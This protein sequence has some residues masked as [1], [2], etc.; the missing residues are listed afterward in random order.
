MIH[1]TLLVSF[2]PIMFSLRSFT[3]FNKNSLHFDS[4]VIVFKL[5][6]TVNKTDDCVCYQPRIYFYK[7]QVCLFFPQAVRSFHQVS[8]FA[9]RQQVSGWKAFYAVYKCR[10]IVN[11]LNRFNRYV[12]LNNNIVFM[13]KISI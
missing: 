13:L 11:S 7:F 4:Y 6:L 10:L 12:Y 3:L 1:T 8:N 5:E 2:M 9:L